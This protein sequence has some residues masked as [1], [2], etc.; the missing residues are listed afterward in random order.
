MR[1]GGE[2][3]PALVHRQDEVAL[4]KV[5][6]DGATAEEQQRVDAHHRAVPDVDLGAEDMA[7]QLC[8]L[9]EYVFDRQ[10]KLNLSLLMT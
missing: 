3:D 7:H 5:D 9:N 4:V 10:D 8:L 6:R 2:A 1:G